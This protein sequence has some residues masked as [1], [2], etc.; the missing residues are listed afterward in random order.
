MPDL[1]GSFGD[2]DD[3]P[4]IRLICGVEQAEL[5]AGPMR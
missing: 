5:D 2:V 1:V 3:L 4:L